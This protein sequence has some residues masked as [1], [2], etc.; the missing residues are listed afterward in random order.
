LGRMRV[1]QEA[2]KPIG[3]WNPFRQTD[4]N[5]SEVIDYIAKGFFR[6]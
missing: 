6:L 5:H 1:L 3:Q 2:L 4:S